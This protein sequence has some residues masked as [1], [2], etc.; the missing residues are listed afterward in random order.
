MRLLA[1]VNLYVERKRALG[2]D[3]SKA[4]STLQAFSRQMGDVPLGHVNHRQVASFLSGPE[5]KL[6]TWRQK[7]GVLLNFFEY[8]AARGELNTLPMPPRLLPRPCTFAPY[9]Y[10]RTELQRLL[11]STRTSQ[12]RSACAIDARTMRALLLF[13]YG[14]GALM[15]EALRLERKQV[16]LK[17]CRVTLPTGRFDRV[18][19]IPICPDVQKVLIKYVRLTERARIRSSR[20]FLTRDGKA[21][22]YVTVCK[23]FQRLRKLAGV[24]RIDG[25]FYQP[26]M[27]DLRST[28]AVHRLTSW[29]K[30]GADLNRMLPA[31]AAYMGQVGLGSTERYLAMTPER[32]RE[33]L[34]E[35][36]PRRRKRRW[37]D[38]AK[39]MK[40]LAEL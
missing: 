7:Y 39:L 12:K 21:L 19:T 14:T 13:L 16:D 30:Q 1:S 11:R 9:I 8:W 27:H 36:S 5:T 29:I 10:S 28:F 23:S 26:R 17:D 40:F 37:R 22:S 33:Q 25:A 15:G 4:Q 35:L 31:L 3:F 24:R 34:A 32:F 6:P 18:R 20:F 38:N 2:F